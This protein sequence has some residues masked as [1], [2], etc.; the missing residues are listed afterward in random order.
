MR[1]TAADSVY[2]AS[3]GFAPD[4]SGATPLDLARRLLSPDP[5]STLR[6]CVQPRGY[7]RE[8]KYGR[9]TW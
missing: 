5:L 9:G 2:L 7:Y 4:L 6:H 1:L 3:G 8:H